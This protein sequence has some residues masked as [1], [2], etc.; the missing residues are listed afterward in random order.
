MTLYV[1][2]CS[3]THG[4]GV[5]YH[6][7][8]SNILA[9]EMDWEIINDSQCGVGNDWILHTTLEKI[10]KKI[11]DNEILIKK[12]YNYIYRQINKTI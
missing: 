3:I 9:K 4:Y 7:S 5:E 6:N 10:I 2:G 11:K 1:N 8:Y 12:D